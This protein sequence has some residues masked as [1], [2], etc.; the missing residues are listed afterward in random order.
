MTGAPYAPRR[1]DL[2]PDVALVPVDPVIA[3]AL[4]ARI[5]ALDPWASLGLSAAAMAERITR[6]WAAT[7]RFV[8]EV[9]GAAAGYVSVRWPFMRGPYLET[10]AVFPEAQRRGLARAVIEWMGREAPPG[11]VDLWLCVSDWNAPA[12]AAYRAL[13]FVEIGP[14]ADLVAPGRTEIFMRRRLAPPI[15]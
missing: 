7:H 8:V 10:I 2:R 12:R 13:G 5:V 15:G 4:A 9:D 3:D 1:H 11:E 14:I 6:P